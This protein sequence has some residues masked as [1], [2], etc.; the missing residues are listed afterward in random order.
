MT[1]TEVIELIKNNGEH[2]NGNNT[3]NNYYKYCNLCFYYNTKTVYIEFKH[4][5]WTR[6]DGRKHSKL[7]ELGGNK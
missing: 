5:K 2:F 3:R 4:F 1:R 6:Y 7:I